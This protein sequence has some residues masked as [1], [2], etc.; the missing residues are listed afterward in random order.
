MECVEHP[1]SSSASMPMNS[2]SIQLL[3]QLGLS[4][5]NIYTFVVELI[6]SSESLTRNL[7]VVDK[8]YRLFGIQCAY[9]GIY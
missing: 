3:S 1:T 8:F 5:P 9:V 6:S 7:R 4:E 2:R